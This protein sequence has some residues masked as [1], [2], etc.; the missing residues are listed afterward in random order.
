LS[1]MHLDSENM[2]VR[3]EAAV[4]FINI[5]ALGDPRKVFGYYSQLRILKAVF[6]ILQDSDSD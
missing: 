6:S 2:L 5:F 3:K 1:A 4:V